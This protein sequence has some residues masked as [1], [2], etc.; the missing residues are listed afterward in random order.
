MTIALEE[1]VDIVEDRADSLETVLKHFIIST[2][3]SLSRLEHSMSDFKDEMKDF[4]DEMKDFKDEMLVFKDEMKDFQKEAERDRKK[5]S[6][7]MGEL[8]NKMGTLVEDI[9]APNIPRIFEQ[10]FAANDLDFF[11]VRVKKP[12]KDRSIRR[13]FDVVTVSKEYL[14]I[15]ETKSNP[16]PEYAREFYESLEQIPD[17]FPEYA[18]RKIIPVF[19][20][21]YIPEDVQTYL[22]RHGIYAMGMKNDTMEILNFGKVVE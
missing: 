7:Q 14:L 17:F 20:S 4:K 8:S 15:N 12:G 2:N 3:N 6:K 11:G 16:K 10:Y 13:E 1:R 18:S 5:M 9:V 21:L 19:S 22:S